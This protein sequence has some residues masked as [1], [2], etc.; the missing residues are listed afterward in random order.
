MTRLRCLGLCACLGLSLT[1]VAC[2]SSNSNG[3]GGG[4]SGSTGWDEARI[5]NTGTAW[6]LNA[7]KGAYFFAAQ[8]S[9]SPT[10]D[11]T[12]KT[13]VIDFAQKVVAKLKSGTP[14]PASLIPAANEIPSWAYAQDQDHTATANGPIVVTSQTSAT[15]LIDGGADPFYTSSYSASGMAQ[16]FYTNGTYII[17]IRIW[18]MGSTTQAKALFTGL[19]ADSLYSCDNYPWTQVSP[20]DP[21]PCP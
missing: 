2:G 8:I 16:E 9:P 7:T 6:W 15:D 18:Q 1:V 19:L 13:T 17:E 21:K 3:G 10:D 20:S 11:A 5:A 14:T 12:G 4:A